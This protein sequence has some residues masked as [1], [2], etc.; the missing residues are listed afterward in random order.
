LA[1][2]GLKITELGARDLGQA[3][4]GLHDDVVEATVRHLGQFEL[5]SA[6]AV[7]R[8]RPLGDAWRWSRKG[9]HDISPLYAA[10]VARFAF[11]TAEQNPDSAYEVRGLVTL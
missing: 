8:S 11:L 10:T 7:A 3:C 5:D 6:V 9:D 4:G 1:E 2:V